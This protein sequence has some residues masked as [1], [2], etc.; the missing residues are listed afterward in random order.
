M[1]GSA[2]RAAILAR[3]LGNGSVSLI[4]RVNDR[5]LLIGQALDLVGQRVHVIPDYI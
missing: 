2:G 4:D 1:A 3:D 5:V